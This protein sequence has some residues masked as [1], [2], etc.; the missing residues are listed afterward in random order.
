LPQSFGQVS[1]DIPVQRERD[2]NFHLGG[3]SFYFFDFDDNVVHL[4]TKIV[5]F[6][7]ITGEEREVSTTDYPVVHPL[8]GKPGSE[9]EHFF[10]REHGESSYRNFR[11]VPKEQL[12]GREQPLVVDM[13]SALQN[14]FQDWRGPSWA[15]FEKAV[16]N[17]RPISVI[18]ARGHHPYTIR[19]AIDLL[20][21]SGDLAAHPN[22]LSVYPVSNPEIRRQLGDVE[23][24][25]STADLKKIAIK[26]A[27]EDAFACYGTNPHHRFGMSDD[28]PHNVAL[29]IEAMRELKEIYPDNAFYAFNTY[30]GKIVREE[31]LVGGEVKRD[32]VG[33]TNEPE[34]T[35]LF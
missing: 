32:L 29:I 8:L 31:V 17:N 35:K 30:G 22:Y 24:K 33:T 14:P 7:K 3:R 15:F 26:V 19:R 10:A 2:R 18:T 5:V 27:V 1:L 25:L 16:N 34:Q 28:D 21:L 12:R 23:M 9:W 4:H 6:H 13:L 20:V 11:E